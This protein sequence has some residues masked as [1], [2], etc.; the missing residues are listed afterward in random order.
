LR[1]ARQHSIERRRRRAQPLP[2]LPPPRRKKNNNTPNNN[3]PKQHQQTTSLATRLLAAEDEAA[4]LRREAQ[5][6]TSPSDLVARAKL[7]RRATALEREAAALKQTAGAQK[8]A[9][10]APVSTAARRL[11]AERGMLG[12]VLQ[13]QAM[14]A[15]AQQRGSARGAAA[16]PAAAA[17]GGGGARGAA[18][19]AGGGAAGEAAAASAA[20]AAALG[21]DVATPELLVALLKWSI[22]LALVFAW[23]G[24]PVAVLPIGTAWPLG[25]I[26]AFPH[27]R[28]LRRAAGPGAAVTAAPFLALADRVS[29]AAWQAAFPEPEEV[30]A[31]LKAAESEG[32]IAGLMRGMGG[33][34][35][36]AS[37]S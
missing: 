18:A 6:L 4:Q 15:R 23:W 35:M 24:S 33:V 7:E 5:R 19:A 25:G 31:A 36:G 26:L 10:A 11:A 37:A 3:N 17:A 30:T 9:S 21:G 34:G 20:A 27:A 29:T 13:Q 1:S 32:G 12:P 28:R 16:A 14:A 22:S 8:R 2:L